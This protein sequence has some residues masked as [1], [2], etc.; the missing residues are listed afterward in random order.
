M[1]SSRG[2][3]I[4]SGARLAFRAVQSVS[5]PLAAR[6]VERW[7]FTPPRKR[8][9]D[10]VKSLLG[11]ARRF[12]LTVE[13]R[14]VVG[15]TWGDGPTVY[16]VHGWGS[17]GGR[18]SAFVTP[19][20]EAGHRVVT[21]DAPGHGESGRGRS[22][23]PEFARALRAVT[24]RHGPAH[25]VVAH[26]LG[27][28]A[29]LLASRWGFEAGRYALLAPAVDPGVWAFAFADALG[30]HPSVMERA[31]IRTE[32]RL[33]FDWSELDVRAVTP[34]LTAPA[35]VVH[36]RGDAT[37]PFDDGAAIAASWPD[38]RLVETTGLGHHGVVRDPAVV[39]QVVRFVAERD[40]A[41]RRAG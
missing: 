9:P 37:V 8:L 27:G 18:L 33:R 31:R 41:Q 2:I 23:A 32:Q 28:S 5:R 4:P 11:D 6:L 19:L 24:E 38:A 40:V 30:A 39:D 3:V 22:S 26:S 13:G 16:L 21:W 17:A 29:T 12:T 1:S 36:D 15:W 34:R 10:E 25:A 14:R 7:F 35:I 20:V